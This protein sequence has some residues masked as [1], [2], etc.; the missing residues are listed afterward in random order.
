MT[1]SLS[2]I[3]QDGEVRAMLAP[4]LNLADKLLPHKRVVRQSASIGNTLALAIQEVLSAEATDNDPFKPR[5]VSTG[6]FSLSR[7]GCISGM[8]GPTDPKNLGLSADT[9]GEKFMLHEVG[10][11]SASGA[12]PCC[13]AIFF[14]LEERTQKVLHSP[15]FER[16][17]PGCD[18]SPPGDGG[19]KKRRTPGGASY[20]ANSLSWQRTGATTSISS[21]AMQIMSTRSGSVQ[22]MSTAAVAC[23]L[24]THVQYN[25]LCRCILC[26]LTRSMAH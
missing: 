20:F 24:L 18:R 21:T 10:V 7:R 15:E 8:D 17:L 11:S 2:N 14:F 9:A 1:A 26:T 5:P 25:L 4:E 16:K 19:S 6:S 22:I 23:R 12:V 13:V 3:Q